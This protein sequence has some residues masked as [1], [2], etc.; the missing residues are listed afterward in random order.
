MRN[1]I[2]DVRRARVA[3][4]AGR[5]QCRRLGL[6][7]L[8]E[9][10]LLSAGYV[11]TNLASDIANTAANTDGHLVNPWGLAY[12]P[13]G[14]FW[15]ANAGTGSSTLY[16]QNG[17]PQPPPP[18]QQLAVTIPAAM[19]GGTGSPTG[20]VFNTAG[21]GFKVTEGANS[22][23]SI[24]LFASLDGV[25]SGWNPT[26]DLHN[27]I[28]AV[29]AKTGASY[30]GLAFDTDSIGRNLLFGADFGTGKIDVF[31]ST[32]TSTTVPGG[33]VDPRIP[34]NYAPFNIQ[35]LGGLLYVT[36][37]LKD[38]PTS[39][40]DDSGPGHGFVDVFNSDGVLQQHL[41][42]HGQL[43]SPWGL[44]IA[45][46]NFGAFSNDLIV[47]NNG[48][49]TIHAYNPHT[50]AFV[51]TM[52]DGTGKPIV[53]DE[54]WA[55]KFGNG[56]VAGPTNTLFFAAGTNGYQNGTF[57]SLQAIPPLKHNAPIVTNLSTPPLQT[58]S[59]QIPASTGDQNPYGVAF[60]PN[61]FPSGGLIHS[62]DV[63]VS[64]FN[65]NGGA[66]GTGTTIVKIGPNGQSSV[67]F[68]GQAGLGLTTALSVLSSGFVIVGNVPNN[69][70]APQQGS[71]L[72]ID[73][74]GH[75]VKTLTDAN[76]LNG[77]WDMTVKD[78][79][80]SAVLFVSN[81]NSGTITRIMMT[82]PAAGPTVKSMTQIASG[83]THRTD[84]AAF[85]I[86]PTGLA[87]NPAMD[88]LYVA[89]T[90]DGSIF[91]IA[92]AS[93]TSDKG[94]GKQ[95]N[96][97]ALPFNGPLGLVL[98]PNG[99]LIVT[100]GDAINTTNTAPP[101]NLI[102]E[103]TPAGKLVGT[104]QV[105]AGPAGGAFG[106]AVSTSNGEIRFAAVDDDANTLEVWTFTSM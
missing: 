99:D 60:V 11:L 79:G 4:P 48:D 15:A 10:S 12:G 72:V 37:A 106:I 19:S 91:A 46:A 47:G 81:A 25:I 22:G 20:I 102:I 42:S 32:F 40:E 90:G 85:V 104:Y 66:Q 94:K 2:R 50:G 86:G 8:E 56:G 31:D 98:A 49:G 82:F 69:G 18:N 95:L 76:L 73:K 58:F 89:S 84:P 100:N 7:A 16:D 59:T 6:E 96:T 57:G 62:G 35:N 88:T 29:P 55:I 13:G 105:D 67:F 77:P 14:P 23:S 75:L 28:V 92:H 93:M 83:Y 38:T 24:F 101:A 34:S 9:R 97:S 64:N 65:A 52:K 61:N 36:Y 63:L 30:D 5:R 68:Q 51:G 39:L 43:N 45:P 70:G 21:S 33:F 80:G 17:T 87:Y 41:I 103:F 3:A 71:L 53:L 27:A 78:M 26:V 54:L 1:W 44:A 74:T